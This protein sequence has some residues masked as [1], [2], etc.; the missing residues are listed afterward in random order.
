MLQ[1]RLRIVYHLLPGKIPS[2]DVWELWKWECFQVDFLRFWLLI[3][4]LAVKEE[5]CVWKTN[6]GILEIWQIWH[7]KMTACGDARIMV[8]SQ[9]ANTINLAVGEIL[10]DQGKEGKDENNNNN[11][12]NNMY[13][14]WKR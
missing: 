11:N 8:V 5:V 4:R 7:L 12:N 13:F 14:L 6:L 3:D 2:V 10:A 9:A 1:V